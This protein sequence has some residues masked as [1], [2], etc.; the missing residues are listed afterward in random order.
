MNSHTNMTCNL[1]SSFPAYKVQRRQIISG[2]SFQD[3]IF[4]ECNS[5]K[6]NHINCILIVLHPKSYLRRAVDLK[7]WIGVG[8][9]VCCK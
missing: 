6:L 4:V 5:L 8:Y 1:K 7:D 2:M 3:T 9:C